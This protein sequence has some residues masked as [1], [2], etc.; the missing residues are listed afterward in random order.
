LLT[1]LLLV[2][3]IPPLQDA[4]DTHGLEADEWAMVLGFLAVPLVLIETIKLSP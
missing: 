3:A 2:L 1:T 4:F